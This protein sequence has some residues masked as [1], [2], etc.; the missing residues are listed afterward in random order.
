MAAVIQITVRD[1]PGGVVI[2]PG[3]TEGVS[4]DD[5]RRGYEV[6]V[7]SKDAATT[8]AWSLA[9]TPDSTGGG[10]GDLD[11]L[12]SSAVLAAP[13]TQSTTFVVDHDGAYLV[14]LVV[15]AGLPGEDTQFLRLRALTQFGNLKLIA[16]GERRDVGGVI[17]ADADPEAWANDQNW[18]LQRLAL[19]IRRASASGRVLTVDSNRGRD[20][21]HAINDPANF[22][23]LPGPNSSLKAVTG[24]K[25]SAEGFGD[26]SSIN[27]AIAYAAAAAGRGE[28]APSATQPYIVMVRSGVYNETLAL[29]PWVHVLNMDTQDAQVRISTADANPHSFTPGGAAPDNQCH[30]MGLALIGTT[31]LVEVLRHKGGT[32]SLHN[33]VVHQMGVAALQGP[34]I[35]TTVDNPGH[36]SALW[37]EHTTLESDAVADAVSYALVFNSP[38]ELDLSNSEVTARAG[39]AFNQDHYPQPIL[40]STDSRVAVDDGHGLRGYGTVDI[41][42]GGLRSVNTQAP[43]WVVLKMDDWGS[44]ADS[45]GA[46]VYLMVDRAEIK[47]DIEFDSRPAKPTNNTELILSAVN[48]L[49][50]DGVV[51]PGAP[52]A[53]ALP[54][55]FRTYTHARSLRYSNTY[56]PPSTPGTDAVPAPIKLGV[57]DVQT[58]IDKLA[59]VA[60]PSLAHPGV[61]LDDAYDGLQTITPW[62]AG[63]GGL[64][65]TI[66]A[67]Q[68]AVQIDGA[69]DPMAMANAR[70]DGGLQATG[71]I[72][73]G[74]FVNGGVTDTVADVGGSEIHLNPNA[75]G[76][77]P[78]IKLGRSVWPN[79]VGAGHR[80][81][82]VALVV[83]GNNTGGGAPANNAPY[84]LRLRTK[85]STLSGTGSLGR[86]ILEAG[87]VQEGHGAGAN[88][89]HAGAVF[90][91]AGSVQEPL[92]TKAA[93]PI[94]LIPG[95]HE[96]PGEADGRIKI[97]LPASATPATLAAAG[98]PTN[99]PAAIGV[100]G[101]IFF[102]L[103]DGPVVVSLDAAD[104]TAVVLTKFEAA[105]IFA[106]QP[107]GAGNPLRIMGSTLG[108][109]S[110]V[111]LIGDDQA[112]ALSAALGDFD[113]GGGAVFT[114]GTFPDLI[115]ISCTQ[116]GRLRVHGDIEADSYIG[117][118][119]GETN[120]ASNVGAGV[121]VFKQKTGVDLE[122]KS[123]VVGAAG[124]LAIAGGVSEVSIEN[125]VPHGY[126][127]LP[128]GAGPHAVLATTLILGVDT[129]GAAPSVT[130]P[131]PV[132]GR[133]LIIKDEGNNASVANITLLRN[134]ATNIEF[135]AADF[136]MGPPPGQD[137]M[138][139]SMYC[140]GTDWFIY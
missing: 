73:I 5:L 90:L 76:A 137:G 139:V 103:E 66:T 17:P 108:I 64:G 11:G 93:G 79:N 96:K 97:A 56:E 135:V 32:L 39:I 72:D 61:R 35:S 43:G 86:L 130:L 81:I 41:R 89:P 69:S 33:C 102:A 15:D 1:A 53:N 129:S 18:N 3:T 133:Q 105:G 122:F 7:T 68:G 109:N 52:A 29:Q 101:K 55:N 95:T 91:Q 20:T 136:V 34:C 112:G 19:L 74:V 92:S 100:T 110:E 117:V 107:G 23:S 63:P 28:P 134:G 118:G 106:D 42:G 80:A 21:T 13:V 62:A 67:D 78:L 22:I 111:Y 119:A 37:L 2:A 120:T 14:R 57:E 44:G 12:D 140:D 125:T 88:A 82:P 104:T 98:A 24:V 126:Q 71:I 58:A 26:F 9:F 8:Y 138:S 114:P 115:E 99:D 75:F 27:D 31:N 132:A 127:K 25:V 54:T 123:L 85:S 60:S 47:G 40:R 45:F 16:A 51:F 131:A 4:R 6:Q 113:I 84:N 50:G 38:G 124:G 70:K 36:S 59:R 128:A 49:T 87:D 30:L 77:G 83:A 65:R 48:F 116:N 46:D 94:W 121:G 10:V